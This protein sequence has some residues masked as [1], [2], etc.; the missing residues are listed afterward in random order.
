MAA[1]YMGGRLP[2]IWLNVCNSMH[3]CTLLVEVS[4]ANKCSNRLC[5]LNSLILW[6][7][8][9]LCWTDGFCSWRELTLSD[10]ILGSREATQIWIQISFPVGTI[11]LAEN[12]NP[13]RAFAFALLEAMDNLK[14]TLK[15]SLRFLSSQHRYCKWNARPRL[16][17]ASCGDKN[18][19][20]KW[21]YWN[22]M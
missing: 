1:I 19:E 5:W 6:S 16:I 22:M 11:E 15:I 12:T 10:D 8:L 14:F 18:N 4:Q 13:W 9:K 3:S 2:Q 17:D 7:S 20:T 21:K